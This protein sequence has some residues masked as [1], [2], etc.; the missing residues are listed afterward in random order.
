M[1]CDKFEKLFIKESENELLSHI[2]I[3]ETCNLEYKKMLV[4]EK[5]IKESKPYFMT[6]KRSKVFIN[7][8]ASLALVVVTS[9]V[10]L[11]NSCITKIAYDES[12]STAAFPVDEYG[13]VDIQ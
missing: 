9:T 5:I 2:Q 3:C 4:T 10:F 1:S 7:I 12:V 6:K 13:L 11:N 8:A